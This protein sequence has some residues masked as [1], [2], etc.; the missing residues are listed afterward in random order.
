MLLEWQ[1]NKCNIYVTIIRKVVME[2]FMNQKFIKKGIVAAALAGAILAPT[3]QALAAETVFSMPKENKEA[4]L[5]QKAL[6]NA[7]AEIHDNT[8]VEKTLKI[9]S[10]AEI[11]LNDMLSG[12]AFAVVGEEGYLFVNAT[13]DENSEFVGKVYEDSAMK[14]VERAE[15]WTEIVSGNV[16]GFI[17]TENLI[18]GKEAIAKAKA[19]LEEQ[20]S[21]TD[22][23]TL[24]KEVIEGSFSVG[25]TLGEETVR[26]AEEEAKRQAEEA[27]R[28]AAEEVAREAALAQRG[29]SVVDYAKQFIGNP[30]VYGGTSLTRGTDCS[31]FVKGV[32]AHFGISMPRTSYSMRRVGYE[33]SFDEIMPGDVVCYSGHVGIYAGNGQ[34]VNAIDESH[35]IGMSSVTY[36]KIITIRRMY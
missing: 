20:Y 29:Q 4:Q 17:K 6:I 24:D 31:G 2:E 30:Y 7:V 9:E 15:D 23:T 18:F 34:I 28:I 13:A 25:E 21:E 32:Y 12:K 8:N 11:K 33:V 19:I 10:G 27:A 14:I 26:L 16:V 35:G 36:A 3:V 22:I 1:R 5:E